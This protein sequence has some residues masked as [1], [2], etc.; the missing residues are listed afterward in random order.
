[1]A[2]NSIVN[3]YGTIPFQGLTNSSKSKVNE[4]YGLSF[5]LGL[6]SNNYFS[7]SSNIEKIKHAIKQLL[8]TNKGERLM[9]PNFGCNLKKY[10][11][12]PLDETTFEEIKKE[13]VTSFYNYIVG[14]TIKKIRV[15]PTDDISVAG[16]NSLNITLVVSLN[17]DQSKMFDVGVVI[18]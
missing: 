9:L 13:I 8:L 2:A 17:T 4:V 11:F 6:R 5:P 10:L 15:V 14:A 12:Q 16:G 1:M 18:S 7:K 3:V